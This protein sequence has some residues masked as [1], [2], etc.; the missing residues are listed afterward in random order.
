LTEFHPLALELVAAHMGRRE[1]GEIAADLER[2]PLPAL[3]KGHMHGDPSSR[4]QSLTRCLDYSWNL[5][6]DDLKRAFASLCLF[7]DSFNAEM[8]VGTFGIED[9]QERLD[10]LYEQSLITRIVDAAGRGRY[11][12]LRPTR[13]YAAI[14][15]DEMMDSVA[16]RARY[17][18]F[19][20]KLVVD[21][22]GI[23]DL[24]KL[25]V[26]DD[27]WRNAIAASDYAE[28][29]EDVSSVDYLSSYLG[30]F[31]LLRGLWSE[32]ERLDLRAVESARR[33]GVREI[34]ARALSNLG[35]VYRSQGRWQE[36]I[37]CYEQSLVIKREYDDRVGEGM[38]LNNLGMVYQSQGRWQ[39]AIDC[40]E[41][42]L[43]IHREYADRVGEGATLNNLGAVYQSQGRSQQAID[44]YEQ[45]L[46]IKREYGDR[47]G[48][49]RTLNNLGMVYD[50][51]GRWQESID[52][53]EQ[54]LVIHREYG[55]RVGEGRTLNNLGM[56]YQSQGRWQE[57]IDCNEQSL[58]ICREY[59]DRVGEGQTLNNLGVVYESQGRSQRAIDCN[60]QSLVI[61][62][63]YGDRVGEGTTLE[64]IALLHYAQ[65]DV[66]VALDW[67]RQAL[68]VL[69]TT[70]DTRAIEE[71]RGLIAEWESQ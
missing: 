67:E 12:L 62:R 50:S 68:Q 65:G 71:A 59:G 34:E 10:Q 19:Y 24:T 8:L 28:A 41:Q 4:H 57:A 32:R 6:D 9:A 46:V 69:E 30:E 45:S 26:L 18:A 47:V 1:V 22:R 44:C 66:T 54:S 20:S 56:V 42:S 21:N 40:Y 53:Y 48:E 58:A 51:Q 15:F 64:N 3:P 60:E 13:A 2:T 43:V 25:A 7:A 49:G 36:A 14:H 29:V 37:D 63:E 17:V 38:T 27:E 39:E 5:L 16:L 23:N 55:D 11:S 70:E 33:A 31:L 61:R 52:C 35:I